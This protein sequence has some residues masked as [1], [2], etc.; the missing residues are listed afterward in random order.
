MGRVTLLAAATAATASLLLGAA[1][2]HASIYWSIRG[3]N[4]IGRASNDLTYINQTFIQN[5]PGN[6]GCGMAADSAHLY[7]GLIQP[8]QIARADLDGSDANLSFV[9]NVADLNTPC[10]TGVN[11]THIFWANTGTPSGVGRANIDGTGAQPDYIGS[12]SEQAC[13]VAISPTKVYWTEQAGF[14]GVAEILSQNLDGSG[15][16]TT[17]LSGESDVGRLP[18]GIA[19]DATHIYWTNRGPDPITLHSNIGRVDLDGTSPDL[20]FRPLP[21]TADPCDVE[22]TS[23]NLYWTEGGSDTIWRSDLDGDNAQSIITADANGGDPC[24]VAVD[25]SDPPGLPTSL[26]TTPASPSPSDSLTISGDAAAASAPIEVFTTSDCSGPPVATAIADAGGSF[27]FVTGLI[28]VPDGS[29]TT[30]RVQQTTANGTSDCDGLNSGNRLTYNDIP[31]A[32]SIT[33]NPASPADDQAPHVIGSS[34]A[35]TVHVF[36]TNNCTGP[37]IDGTASGGSYDIP[38]NVPEGSTTDLSAN[39]TTLGGTSPCTSAIVYRDIPA[40]PTLT[41]DPASPAQALS[42]TVNGTGVLNGV[43]SFYAN[44]TCSGLPQ[45][46]PIDGSGDFSFATPVADGSASTF[47]SRVAGSP[48]GALSPCTPISFTELASPAVTGSTPASPANEIDPRIRGTA[49]TDPAVTVRLFDNPACSGA[50]RA[51]G[52]AAAFSGA[53]IGVNVADGS[54]T[55]FYAAAA[56]NGTETPCSATSVTYNEL[57]SRPTGLSTT[58]ASPAADLSPRLTGNALAGTVRIYKAADCTGPVTDTT[59]SG[60]TFDVAIPIPST[61]PTTFSATVTTPGGKSACSSSTSYSPLVAPTLSATAPASP[62]DDAH[63]Q[64]RGSV[65][66]DPAVTVRLFDNPACTGSPVATGTAAELNGAGITV[67]VPD[68]STKTLHAT[69]AANG[70]ETACSPGSVTYEN[71]VPGLEV[72]DVE[73]DR[74]RGTATL[75]VDA[76]VPGELGIEKTRNVKG[77]GP[78]ELTRAGTGELEVAPRGDAKEQLRRRGRTTVNARVT[79]T[80]PGGTLGVREVV[81]LIFAPTATLAGPT[82]S[83]HSSLETLRPADPLSGPTSATLTAARNEFESFQVA[84]SAAD[85]PVTG[86]QIELAT[87]LAGPT[88][89]IPAASVTIYREQTL[90]LSRPSDLEGGTGRWP[91]ALIPAVDPYYGERRAAFPVDVAARTNLVAWVDVL[92][93]PNQ[94]AGLYRGSLLVRGSGVLSVLPIKLTVHDFTLPSTSTLASSFGSFDHICE[95][96]YGDRCNER[97]GWEINSLYARAGLENRVSL[98]DPAYR[99]PVGGAVESFR[100][101]V[102]PLL[103]GRSPRDEEGLWSPVRLDGAALTSIEVDGGGIRAWERE[104]REGR[105]ADRAFFYACDEPGSERASWRDCKRR[106]R[107]AGRR[108]RDLDVLITSSLGDARRFQA[109]RLIDILVPLV[110]EMDDKPGASAYSGDQRP[111]YNSFL[112]KPGRRLWLYNSC[113]SHGC[114]PAVDGDPYWEGWPSY[115]IDQPASEH[116]AMGLLAYEYGVGGELYYAVDWDLTSAW[117]SQRSFGGNGDG[118]LFYPGT[119]AMVGGTHDIPIESIRLKRIRDGREDFEYAALAARSGHQAEAVGVAR[120]LFPSMYSTDVTPVAFEQAR[121]ALAG[122]VTPGLGP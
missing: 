62:A 13:G 113:N 25:D 86:L 122:L 82:V 1:T 114:S 93:P 89:T 57:P 99:P 30:F 17:V 97:Q 36:K 56:A 34:V 7:W 24:G 38:I 60:G 14:S 11:A 15:G 55:T 98:S 118:T 120:S 66:S 5:A 20:D 18:C 47:S 87:P 44:G 101:Y 67:H 96:H 63:P 84:V 102:Q 72:T 43:A 79:L 121:L 108:W 112:A 45:T 49:L 68:G 75:T 16:I 90:G 77:F 4:E 48:S 58:P 26:A 103:D 8:G 109:E 107:L 91:D 78:V 40:A 42:L 12:G 52:S 105:F 85:V 92:V 19:V 2:V 116:R 54:A 51:T 117:Q 100:R 106:A 110:N 46:T 33:T 50:P 41:T 73:L 53:G 83:V 115:V 31:D 59:S 32:P 80:G 22:V 94:P 3:S 64:V 104:A 61:S 81:E 76:N 88:G 95:A 111:G 27:A 28:T 69:A 39:V 74:R 21:D 6:G 23:A 70:T 9:P 37:S 29:S 10:G 35:G 119:P 65:L 71:L